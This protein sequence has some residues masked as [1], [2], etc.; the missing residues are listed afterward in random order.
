[1]SGKPGRQAAAPL[2]T[3]RQTTWGQWDLDIKGYKYTW[4]GLSGNKISTWEIF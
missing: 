3:D 4:K 1:M 2:Q